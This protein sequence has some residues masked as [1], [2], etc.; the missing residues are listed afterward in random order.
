MK[1]RADEHV[2]PKIVQ[3]LRSLTLSAGWELTEVR[4]FH[5]ARTADETWVPQFADEGGRAILTADANMLKRPH[6]IVAIQDAQ[7]MGLILPPSWA[8][9]QRH[10]QAASLIRYWPEIE[11]AFTGGQP[12]DFWRLPQTLFS[13]PLD[14]LNINYSAAA[15]ASIPPA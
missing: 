4:Q 14:K 1:V 9:A 6:M 11:A 8:M 10:L 12:G 15:A 2:S 3:A 7:I 13:G 5:S